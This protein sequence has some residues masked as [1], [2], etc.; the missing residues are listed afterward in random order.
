MFLNDQLYLTVS[1]GRAQICLISFLSVDCHVVDCVRGGDDDR[2]A[3]GEADEDV[4]E[5]AETA[6]AVL[7]AAQAEEEEREHGRQGGWIT[8]WVTFWKRI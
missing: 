1:F 5:T 2:G 7:G 4:G 3:G 8:L 6:V